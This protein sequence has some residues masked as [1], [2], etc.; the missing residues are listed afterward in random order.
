M[1]P[2]KP[3]LSLTRVKNPCISKIRIEEAI[4]GTTLHVYVIHRK[5]FINE[6]SPTVLL[7][8]ISYTTS[9]HKVFIK[10]VAT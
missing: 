6:T 2:I 1:K 7:L 10:H 9:I 8:E 3:V 5:L 4:V